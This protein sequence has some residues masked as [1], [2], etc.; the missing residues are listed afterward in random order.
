[1]MVSHNGYVIEQLF[2]PLVVLTSPA[3]DEL[4]ELGKDCVRRRQSDIIGARAEA[5]L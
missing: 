3:F 5:R 4:R 1:M 2:S